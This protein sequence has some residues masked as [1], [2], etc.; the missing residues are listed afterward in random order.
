[1]NHEALANEMRGLRE[2]VTGITDTAVAAAD[3]MLIAADTADTIEAESLAAIAAAGLGIARR[4]TAATGRGVFRQTVTHGSQGCAAFY[5]VGDTALM[6]V[7]G[8]EG[9]DLERLHEQTR[10][11]LGRIGSILAGDDPEPAAG[12]PYTSG[13]FAGAVTETANANA[14]EGV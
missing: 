3:G 14:N 4:A 5:A 10:P 6:I 8:D 2:R 9:I 11:V 13:A 1:M 12:T 7:L